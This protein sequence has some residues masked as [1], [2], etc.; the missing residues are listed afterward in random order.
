LYRLGS[1]S[2]EEIE[3]M[4]LIQKQ[5][6]REMHIMRLEYCQYDTRQKQYDIDDELELKK[7]QIKVGLLVFQDT[8]NLQHVTD[9]FKRRFKETAHCIY[10]AMTTKIRLIAQ[11]FPDRELEQMIA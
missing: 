7:Y 5:Q 4:G 6:Q 10:A 3:T 2:I 8:I 9:P 11:R 1:I